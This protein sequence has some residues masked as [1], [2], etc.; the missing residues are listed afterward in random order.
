MPVQKMTKCP[1]CHGAGRNP[2][3]K[4]CRRC[5]GSGEINSLRKDKPGN[6]RP[7]PQPNRDSAA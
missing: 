6:F 1:V 7:V 5:K 4:L 3:G 2:A